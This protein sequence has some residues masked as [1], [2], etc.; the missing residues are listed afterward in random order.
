MLTA[1]V[2]LVSPLLVPTT[3]AAAGTGCARYMAVLVPGTTE[4]S[5]NADPS[6]PAGMLG[7]VG[8]ELKKKYGDQIQVVY[9][10]YPA[11]AFFNGE[12]YASSKSEGDRATSDAMAQC[13]SSQFVLGGYSQ[14]AHVANDVA[15]NIGHGLG[16]VAPQN[17][18]SVALL[19]NPKTGTDG[20]KLLGPAQSGQGIAGPAPEG[21]GA[22]AGKVTE[23]CNPTDAYC[24]TSPTAN[25][26]LAS[27]GRVIANPPGTV[28][29]TTAAATT[30]T[31]TPN[32]GDTTTVAASSAAGDGSDFR[33]A[34]SPGKWG[35]ADLSAVAGS[36]SR[37]ADSVANL[38]G[39]G[40]AVTSSP[41]AVDIARIAQQARLVTETLE[42][43]A[44]TQTWLTENPGVRDTLAAAPE[45]SPEAMTSQVLGTV[46]KLD[47]PA[48]LEAASS[49]LDTTESLLGA[50]A[51][52]TTTG[53]ATS[54]DSL[55]APAQTLA[56]GTGALAETPADQLRTATSVLSALQPKSIIDQ[57]LN[58]VAGVT[59]VDYPAVAAG[60]QQ[61][62][63]KIVA[64]DIPAAHKLAGD[65]N[66][67]LSPLVKM[68]AGVDLKTVSRLVAMIPDPSG[69]AATVSMVAGLLGNVDVIRL[70]RNVGQIQEIAW[71]VIETGNPLALSQ[72][73]PV[74]LDLATVAA[75]VLMPGQKMSADQL[76][77][78]A[79][80]VAALMGMQADKSDFVGLG[81]SAASLASS[82]GAESVALLAKEG[83]TAANFFASGSHQS[84]AEWKPTGKD[85]AL[86]TIVA[87]FT[88]AIGG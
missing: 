87:Q 64:G 36:A 22:L 17:V 21:F 2:A 38:Q 35:T 11:E 82:E 49:V 63:G 51:S 40:G 57:V 12:A 28:T 56:S 65:L 15:V 69:T 42:P 74:G 79:D 23:I 31:A 48:L 47:I 27:L 70:A 14:G 7:E 32:V 43:V 78:P 33:A 76:N 75:G 10:P 84:Y 24:N 16:P 62:P 73:L 61:L 45:S 5:V 54:Y 71:K 37:L 58:V 77:A 26:F 1:S 39:A 30:N 19:A 34:I 80:P 46:G 41:R 81:T 13:T 55:V 83:L 59:S 53:T 20:A 8:S 6:T 86:E 29:A 4:T 9:P 60:L 88:R 18:L 68:A 72:L 50:R 44:K 25:P 3:A 66:N 85:T 52:G 67:Q